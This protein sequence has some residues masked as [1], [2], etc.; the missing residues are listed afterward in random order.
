MFSTWFQ[1][2]GLSKL[3]SHNER[4][5]GDEIWE[6]K[7]VLLY[8]TN[9]QTNKAEVTRC[10]LATEAAWQFYS[11]LFNSTEADLRSIHHAVRSDPTIMVIGRPVGKGEG[12]AQKSIIGCADSVVISCI[13][14]Q[15]G[16]R[17]E[18]GSSLVLWLLITESEE[19]KPSFITSW[20]R[21][22][23]G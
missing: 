14:Y 18:S 17:D 8:P 21:Q 19:Q 5:G 12:H 9:V 3:M 22:G 2:L 13:T 1:D 15:N 20:R 23:F 4:E 11:T 10:K 7:V 16:I 6:Y